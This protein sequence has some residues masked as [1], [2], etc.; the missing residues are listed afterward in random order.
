MTSNTKRQIS[1]WLGGG[2][3]GAVLAIL[4]GTGGSGLIPTEEGRRNGAYLDPVGIPTICEGWT[5]GVQLGDWAS[6][7]QCDELTLRGI[8]D[9]AAVFVAHVPGG[10]RAAMPP[11]SIAAFLSFIYNV[12]PG[13]AGQKDGFVWLRNGRHS[14]MLR[15]LQAGDVRAACLQMPRWATAQGKP[16]RGLKLRRQ[17]EMALCLQ[18]LEDAP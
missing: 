6:D 4:V 16:L 11:A 7:A 9:A 3:A 14:T 13:A 10:V 18:D 2:V 12:G 8:R 17:R 1:A 15:L 5:H